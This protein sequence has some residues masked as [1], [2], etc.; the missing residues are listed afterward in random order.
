MVNTLKQ[1]N[2]MQLVYDQI[3]LNSIIEFAYVFCG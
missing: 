2:V 1:D 3:S